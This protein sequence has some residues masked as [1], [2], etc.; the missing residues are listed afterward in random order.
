MDIEHI[1][2]WHWAAVGLLAGLLLAGTRLFYAHDYQ[3]H[4][5]EQN[6]NAVAFG[7]RQQPVLVGFFFGPKR[8]LYASGVT[9]HPPTTPD[10]RVDGTKATGVQWV[11]GTLHDMQFAKSRDGSGKMVFEEKTAEPFFHRS[12]IPYKANGKAY[13]DVRAYL[14]DVAKQSGGKGAA[15]R[16]AWWER[17]AIAWALY[18]GAGL[19]LIGGVWPTLLNLLVGAGLGRKR[20]EPAGVDLSKYKSTASAATPKGKAELSDDERR[21]LDAVAA[22]MEAD[23]AAGASAREPGG[24]ALNQDVPVRELETAPLAGS[25]KEDHGKPKT[26]DGDF[27]PTEIHHRHGEEPPKGG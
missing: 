12:A 18:P 5:L 6:F 22:A 17:P 10:P 7:S 2:R 15:Y 19:L 4:S 8:W 3:G 23:L 20:D 1:K 9:I 11:T 26:F 14:E 25:V 13:A 21:Q 24:A 27:Y 16:V